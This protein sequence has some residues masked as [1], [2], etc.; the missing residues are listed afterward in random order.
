MPKRFS[1]PSRRLALT[2][3]TLIAITIVAAG[4]AIWQRHEEASSR[5]RR[6]LT[7]LSVVLAE[8]TARS[9]QGVD[10]VLQEIQARVG[11][12]SV[13]NREQSSELM[14]S[15]S[16]R[17]FLAERSK[18]LPQ[19]KALGVLDADGRLKNRSAL[20]PPQQT[21]FTRRDYFQYLSTHN[22]PDVFISAPARAPD[23]NWT[24]FLARRINDR[25]G[26]FAGIAVGL[27]DADY[28]EGFYRAIS[29]EVGDAVVMLRRDG[30]VLVRHP[31]LESA[32]GQL[33]SPNS[34][35]Y[36]VIA[37]GGGAYR[38]PGFL[39]GVPRIVATHP[40]RGYPL[41]INVAATEDNALAAWRRE[42]MLIAS[43]ALVAVIGFT[44]LFRAL[45]ARS[46]RLER[47]TSEL[48]LVAEALRESESRFRDFATITSDW[49]WE[50]DANHRFT[51]LSETAR[52]FGNDP[53]AILGRTRA[54]LAATSDRNAGKWEE[55]MAMLDRHQAF[56]D[57][58]YT[59]DIKTGPETI[60][61]INGNPVFDRTGRFVGYRGT[62]R[63]V[64]AQALSERS[65]RDAKMAAEVAN[66]AKSQFLA[67]ISHELRTPLNAIIGFSDMMM[68]GLAGPI[69]DQQE[70]YSRIIN[71]SGNHLL[72][73]VNDLLD[74]A[75][76]DAGKFTLQDQDI[77]PVHFT[78]RCIEMVREAAESQNVQLTAEVEPRTPT[79]VGDTR[80]LKQVMLNLLSNAIKFTGSG[81]KVMLL[82]RRSCDGGIVFAVRDT[83]VGMD[84]AEIAVALEPFGQVDAGLNRRHD[85]AGL[86]LPL[87]QSLVEQH[88]GSF[89]IDS[90][91]GRGTTVTV[92]LPADRVGR[93]TNE[94]AQAST[95]A[96]A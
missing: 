67:N 77:D 37:K 25:K 24:L 48:R 27:L 46:R 44:I 33:L 17:E 4:L 13:E 47:Q 38:A 18:V 81:G 42:A 19:A 79:F 15:A 72:H 82:V 66:I 57:F 49:L 92:T 71:A 95:A 34:R 43:A 56:R 91:K 26:D 62:A 31:H 61:S 29:P 96:A 45:A 20:L 83:G 12:G 36:S 85:G 58:V 73:I 68:S 9:L 65:L 75:K 35:W 89:Q 40:V 5:C 70:E 53:D 39:G 59:R 76:I 52:R 88:G 94:D 87:A 22:D 3:F 2:G 28:F 1:A 30:T 64:T 23:G 21:D 93:R 78:D 10:L 14:S 8:Q 69:H 80:R 84:A 54:E 60:V 16:L 63:D 51:Y 7:K 90:E 55:H 11:A 86:G 32:I 6:E 74:I 41:V 50:S